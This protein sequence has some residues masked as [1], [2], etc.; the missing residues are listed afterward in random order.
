MHKI[1]EK[2]VR[3]FLIFLGIYL[4][5]D[6][7]IH[8]LNIR[9]NSVIN[10]WSSSAIVY[11]KLLN[12]IYASFVFLAA[13]LVL[14]VQANLEKYKTLIRVSTIWA[15]FH[16]FLLIYLTQTLSIMNNFYNLSSLYVWM[17]FYNEYLLF[18]AFLAFAYAILIFIWSN[19][20]K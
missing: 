11:A 1:L 5:G 7:I 4:I 9:L 16:G 19:N 17:P 20:K 15:I 6:G 13:C 10:T 14:V 2:V 3:I 18:E 8:L 12:A